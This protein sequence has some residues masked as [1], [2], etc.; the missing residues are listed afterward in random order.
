VGHCW[1]DH[2]LVRA[3]EFSTSFVGRQPELRSSRTG[4][5]A[6]PGPPQLV[7]L[8]IGWGRKVDCSLSCCVR[9]RTRS[10]SPSVVMR[11]RRRC[12][13]MGVSIRRPMAEGSAAGPARPVQ[14]DGQVVDSGHRRSQMGR[15]AVVAS[16]VVCAAPQGPRNRH[17]GWI[18]SCLQADSRSRQ[19]CLFRPRGGKCG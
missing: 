18:T 1:Q 11:R 14:A 16:G 19:S 17:N 13:P 15:P 10:L 2:R 4:W 7:H 6:Q 9:C 5:K 8:A 12:S 3:G